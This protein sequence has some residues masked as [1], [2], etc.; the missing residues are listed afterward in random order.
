MAYKVKVDVSPVYELLGSF[1]I[2]VARR[3]ILDIDMG[4]E[5]I[6]D[7]DQRLDE[8]SLA[9]FSEASTWPFDDYDVLYAWAVIRGHHNDA[10]SFLNY[11]DTADSGELYNQIH[12]Y[13][14]Q[15]T[16]DKM[17]T[18]RHHYV[19]LLRK[20]NEVYFQHVNSSYLPLLTEDASEK[21]LLLEKM[22][23]FALID[24]ATG[25]LVVSDK[26]PVEQV[27]LLPTIHLRPI[28]T[29][30]FYHG[31]L[32]IQYP[33]DLPLEDENEAPHFLLRLTRALAAPERLK[34]LRYLAGEPKSAAEILQHFDEPED[35]MMHHLRRLR[36][37][38]LLCVHLEQNRMEKYCLRMDGIAE[39]QIFLE[40]YIQI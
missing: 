25:G 30:C 19:P 18:I 15:L 10:I 32:L 8:V 14:P 28:N 12:T 29:Y 7:I 37:A 31:M 1:L 34:L 17:E 13:L 21:L 3:W 4:N 23:P 20:W 6:E 24:Y 39:L 16:T 27:I 26:L 33:V 40:T 36:V 38:G 35:R 9:L 5:W 2:Y 22:E 11:L